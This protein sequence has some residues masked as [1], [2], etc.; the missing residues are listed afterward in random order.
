[1]DYDLLAESPEDRR[2]SEGMNIFS[3]SF[4]TSADCARA[5]RVGYK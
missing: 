3:S 2:A 5:A 1:M 4:T